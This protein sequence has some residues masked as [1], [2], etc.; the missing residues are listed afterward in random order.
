M[1]HE[2]PLLCLAASKNTAS[3]VVCAGPAGR[4]AGPGGEL[5][6]LAQV[7]LLR[8]QKRPP[9][10]AEGPRGT[11]VPLSGFLGRPGLP[12]FVARREKGVPFRIIPRKLLELMQV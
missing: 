9:G 6:P 12:P 2:A 7:W 8:A 10:A 5:L 1:C 3:L 4:R 11:R